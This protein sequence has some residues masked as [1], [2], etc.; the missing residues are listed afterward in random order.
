MRSRRPVAKPEWRLLATVKGLCAPQSGGYFLGALQVTGDL[1][2]PAQHPWQ[3]RAP[4][5]SS[6]LGHVLQAIPRGVTG[7]ATRS[8]GS[9]QVPAT[10]TPV[11]HIAADH[12]MHDPQ[13]PAGPGPQG[14]PGVV[15]TYQGGVEG[16]W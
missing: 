6:K 13:V 2:R 9:A 4:H 12:Q 3:D 8:T 10:C 1:I 16:H 7:T 11:R 15:R 5:G 14:M